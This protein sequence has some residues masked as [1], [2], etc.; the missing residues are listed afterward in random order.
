MLKSKNTPKKFRVH[1][2]NN[3]TE[4]S[5]LHVFQQISPKKSPAEQK[6]DS[7]RGKFLEKR[8]SPNYGY[9][10]KTIENVD[11]TKISGGSKTWREWF[12]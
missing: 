10:Q 11:G 7:F 1:T 8:L 12:L 2:N 4:T 5:F 6:L 3:V 9:G